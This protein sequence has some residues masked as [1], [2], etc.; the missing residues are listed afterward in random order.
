VRSTLIPKRSMQARV[1]RQSALVANPLMRDV[2]RATEASIATLCE[3]DLSPG[4]LM[5]PSTERGPLILIDLDTTV[6]AMLHKDAPY[7]HLARELARL[8]TAFTAKEIAVRVPTTETIE[9]SIESKL[10]FVEAVSSVTRSVTTKMGFSEDDASWIELA[11]HEAVIN[12][13]THGNKCAD[14]KEVDVKFV[15]DQRG[16]TVYVRDRGDGFDP[17]SLPNPLDPANL[18]NPAGRGIFYMRT[19]MDE[20]EYSTHPEGGSIVRM[21]KAKRFVDQQKSV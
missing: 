19:F 10:E 1:E 9:L 12:A 11:I 7:H 21:T 18:L 5:M 16:L 8:M 6:S 17:D 3:I 20:V 2:P 4:M 14:S 13:I 15:I